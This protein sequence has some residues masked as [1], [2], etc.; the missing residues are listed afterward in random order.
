[1]ATTYG[2]QSLQRVLAPEFFHDVVSAASEFQNSEQLVDRVG[3]WRLLGH[4]ETA[5]LLAHFEN[6]SGANAQPNT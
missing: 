1:M 6:L 2:G 4:D 5:A 3:A